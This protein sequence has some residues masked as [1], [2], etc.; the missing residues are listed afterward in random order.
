M[1]EICIE[2][3]DR[4]LR[5]TLESLLTR[6]NDMQPVMEDIARALRNH[7]EDAFQDERSPFGAPW[8]DLSNVTKAIRA[9][10]GHWPGPILQVTGSSGLAGSISSAAGADWASL[11]VGKEYAA[12]HQFGRAD[13]RFYGGPLAPIPARPF[14]PIDAAGNL[15]DTLRNEILAILTDALGS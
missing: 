7:T 14:L 13:N 10:S 15:P 11:G 8:A 12:T 6:V 3:D 1:T 2:V 5:A 4:A 9:K